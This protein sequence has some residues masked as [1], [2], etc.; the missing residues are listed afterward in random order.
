M[1]EPCYTETHSSG[2]LSPGHLFAIATVASYTSRIHTGL[3][4]TCS[5]FPQVQVGLDAIRN[6]GLRQRM[7][8]VNEVH[9]AIQGTGN[10]DRCA[11]RSRYIS[12]AAH[13]FLMFGF[14]ASTTTGLGGVARV[15]F[16]TAGA[17]MRAR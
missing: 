2:P 12:I 11:F 8:C 7:Q 6:T 10:Y 15:I 17:C 3:S 16:L 1:A 13:S 9:N 14:L 4:S 5:D